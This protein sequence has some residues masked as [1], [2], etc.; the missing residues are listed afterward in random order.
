MF[1]GKT[2]RA[3]IKAAATIPI[4]WIQL[5]LI[6]VATLVFRIKLVVVVVR[7]SNLLLEETGTDIQL[8]HTHPNQELVLYSSRHDQTISGITVQVLAVSVS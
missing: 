3:K 5:V 2:L 8:Y 1:E 7:R 4:S 6:V